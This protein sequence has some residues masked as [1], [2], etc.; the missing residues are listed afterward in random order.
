MD[1]PVNLS[2]GP[3]KIE[4]PIIETP[5]VETPPIQVLVSPHPPAEVPS[6]APVLLPPVVKEK[7]EPML[8]YILALILIVAGLLFSAYTLIKNKNSQ[9]APVVVPTSVPRPTETAPTSIPDETVNWK[10]YTNTKYRYELK[11]PEG[12]TVEAYSAKS[13]WPATGKDDG[14]LVGTL[15]DITPVN[16][17]GNCSDLGNEQSIIACLGPV[18]WAQQ[19]RWIPVTIGGLPAVRKEITLKPSPATGSDIAPVGY[20]Y[21]VNNG[22]IGLQI[23]FTDSASRRLLMDQILST[24][25]FLP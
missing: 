17:L 10:I 24:F 23:L 7:K 8:F 16:A 25:K 18:S 19:G 21:Y 15:I 5:I 11:Y 9:I 1:E 12:V 22:D 2:I 3:E 13:S 20:V 4:T 14:I 6:P